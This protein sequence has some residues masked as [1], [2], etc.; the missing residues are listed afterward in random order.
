MFC[1][2]N[3]RGKVA[4]LTW[5]AATDN[6]HVSCSVRVEF[7]YGNWFVVLTPLDYNYLQ[8]AS[9]SVLCRRF[10]IY[11]VYS[12]C[13]S[14]SVS[15]ESIAERQAGVEWSPTTRST[16]W[17]FPERECSRESEWE[18]FEFFTRQSLVCMQQW[19][20]VVSCLQENFLAYE[21]KRRNDWSLPSDEPS[22]TFTFSITISWL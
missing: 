3:G 15:L 5:I 13:T 12:I 22:W 2:S 6:W 1:C 21:E 20:M 11:D 17:T 19:K 8:K 16:Q 7:E 9:P 14:L 10:L 18:F 4:R